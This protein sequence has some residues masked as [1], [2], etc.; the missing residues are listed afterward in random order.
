M[1]YCFH[2]DFQKHQNI[3]HRFFLLSLKAAERNPINTKD[4]NQTN[5]VSN[6]KKG[7]RNRTCRN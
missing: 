1:Y 4:S 3:E 5:Y 7:I 2:S 6:I